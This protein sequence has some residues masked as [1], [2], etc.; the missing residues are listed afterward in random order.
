MA[1]NPEGATQGAAGGS[2]L[3]PVGA[4]IGGVL[5]GFFGSDP[6]EVAQRMTDAQYKEFM[7]LFREMNTPEWK[8]TPDQLRLQRDT[9]DYNEAVMA[10]ILGYDFAWRGETAEGD[11]YDTE[12]TIKSLEGQLNPLQQKMNDYAALTKK[13]GFDIAS[14]SSY[15]RSVD[16]PDLVNKYRAAEREYLGIFGQGSLWKPHLETQNQINSLNTQI[17]A[18]ETNL[19][20]LQSIPQTEEAPGATAFNQMLASKEAEF[21]LMKGQ[22]QSL[23][24]TGLQ[25]AYETIRRENRAMMGGGVSGHMTGK[26]ADMAEGMIPA[27]QGI[28]RDYGLRMQGWKAGEV[29]KAANILHGIA[30]DTPL[31]NSQMMPPMPPAPYVDYAQQNLFSNLGTLGGA[32]IGSQWNKPQTQYPS[33]GGYSGGYPWSFT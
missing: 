15:D 20:D 10:E 19:T 22:E 3:G 1:F 5:G 16:D 17:G 26:M 30:F 21:G 24:D 7:E 12:Q 31:N 8:Y 6:A 32:Y 23:L 18:A 11:I 33:G 27:R 2:A 13:Y 4:A 25:N 14:L 9:I 28:E 29:E